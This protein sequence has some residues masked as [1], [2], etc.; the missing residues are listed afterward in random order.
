MRIFG[1]DPEKLS[2]VERYEI[3]F[4]KFSLLVALVATSYIALSIFWGQVAKPSQALL[5]QM[6]VFLV[7]FS[8]LLVTK[9]I[10]LC[11]TRIDHPKIYHVLRLTEFLLMAWGFEVLQQNHSYDMVAI[12]PYVMVIFLTIITSLCK[13]SATGYLYVTWFCVV[14]IAIMIVEMFMQKGE[15]GDV[16]IALFSVEF[17]LKSI[18]Y[19]TLFLFAMLCGMICK[20]H[21][22]SEHKNKLL[23]TERED[24]YKQLSQAQQEIMNHYDKLIVTNTVLEETNMKLSSSIAEFYTMQQI[25]KAISSIFDVNELLCYVNDIIIGVM[26]VSNASI[27]LYNEEENRLTL[28]TTNMREAD[29]IEVLEDNVNSEVLMGCLNSGIPLVDNYADADKYQFIRGREVSSIVCIPIA[30]KARRYGLVLIEH[31]YFMAFDDKNIRLMDIIG[32]QVAIAMENAELYQ[33][34]QEMATKDGLTGAYNRI[35]FSERLQKELD[36]AVAN[37][38]ELSLAIF[39]VD[40]FKRFNDTY[41]HLFGDKVIRTI[42]RIVTEC[43]RKRDIVARYGGEELVILF[44]QTSVEEA[45]EIVENIRCR[46]A[47]TVVTDGDIL[48]SV[49]VSFGVSSYPSQ[50]SKG[51]E[52]LRSADAALYQAKASG[53]NCVVKYS[54]YKV[55]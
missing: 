47:E 44:P 2:K 48:A 26:G 19:F 36:I 13:N 29:M 53:R 55:S 51:A 38:Y 52:L 10:L 15:S 50:V 42:S 9:A 5:S 35:Y 49:T 22:R 14:H 16:F 27:L 40:F 33:K 54:Q 41:G 18:Y 39:D 3:I 31:K 20:D 17:L 32:Q 24:K 45:Y 46:I 23:V 7:M 6:I 8:L 4:V 37:N 28:H 43:V 34:M 12:W 1:C 30:T 21:W 11:T 25:S